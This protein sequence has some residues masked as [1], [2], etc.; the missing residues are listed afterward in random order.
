MTSLSPT[1]YAHLIEYDLTVSETKW[2]P[3]G[4]QPTRAITVNNGIPGPTIR[5]KV[6]DTARIRVHNKL[7]KEDT[8][9]HWHGLLLPNEQD[10]VPDVTTP[11]IK[12]GTT[13]TFEFPI[14]HAGTY[15]YHSHTGYQEQ[16]GVF[17][18]IVV[19]PARPDPE[20][21]DREHVVVLSDWSK[22]SAEEIMRSLARGTEWYEIRKKT[23]QSVVGAIK[24]GAFKEF[25]QR[26]R[27]R[28]LP[29]DV[30]DIAYD[31]FLANGAESL[32]LNGK[33]GERVKLRFINASAAT[34]FY[35]QSSTGPLK[36]V[37]ADGPNV[38]PIKVK[39]LFMGMAETYDVIVTVPPSG[40]WEIRATAQDG[41]G[42][43]S[44]WLGSGKNHS[45]PDVPKPDIYRMDGHL[46]A[47]LNQGDGNPLSDEE[48]LAREPERPLSPYQR[49]RAP[50]PTEIPAHL[51]RRTITLR[52][53][54]DMER[55]VW[56]FNDKT[57]A[58]DG[59]IPIKKGEVIRLVMIN[60]TMMH[61]PLHLHGA[62]F[63]L[64]MGNGTH[65]P[66]KHTI[67][68]PPMAKRIVEFEANEKG[69]WLFH[70]H[71]LYHMHAGMTR[72]F[73]YQDD[74]WV[75]PPSDPEGGEAIANHHAASKRGAPAVAK[76]KHSHDTT[77]ASDA[78][79]GTA[80]ADGLSHIPHGGGHEHD[81]LYLLANAS[82]LTSYSTGTVTLRDSRND[83]YL[84]WEGGIDD[85][86]EAELD[87]GWR[88]YIDANRGYRFGLRYSQDQ[89]S[90][91]SAFAGYDYR[92]PYLVWSRV[93]VNTS[94]SARV[95]LEKE[96]PITT[97]F[98]AFAALEYDTR[99][100]WRTRVGGRFTLTKYTNFI[101][102]HHSDYGLG[103][104][105]GITY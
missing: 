48:A 93:E 89:K 11:P 61:H 10:G 30:S 14:T 101:L 92:L 84:A 42:H 94:G 96:L 7:Q 50:H 81:P 100:S 105:L 52:A 64:L 103:I 76:G 56:S 13:H 65:A 69:D 22:E 37:A 53:S 78:S 74:S 15:W 41:S 33:P 87:L 24:A 35:V 6:G 60:D 85:W 27:S 19:D 66:L 21:F 31:A 70:C 88:R 2:A 102:E 79:H 47:A 43:A 67:D 98:S 58:E 4:R 45:A 46:L 12:P 26:E 25:W 34:Y 68:L 82:F 16:A 71:L 1:L 36:I 73:S 75:P 20:P 3:Q 23:A 5:F 97:R 55:Y 95:I 9:I 38:Q 104:G 8:S 54:G 39:R 72:I 32:G 77:N 99:E 91:V 40:R 44:V 28:M 49:L 51:P 80:S 83:W 63:R 17:G 62:F 18:S 59:V 29:M 90:R 57:F 86:K